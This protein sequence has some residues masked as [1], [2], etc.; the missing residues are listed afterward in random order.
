MNDTYYHQEVVFYE[1]KSIAKISGNYCNFTVIN[2]NNNISVV[3]I[4]GKTLLW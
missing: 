4:L 3:I 2:N 1:I